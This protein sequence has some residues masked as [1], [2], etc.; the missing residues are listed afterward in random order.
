M[1]SGPGIDLSSVAVLPAPLPAAPLSTGAKPLAAAT[2]R[3]S[4]ATG[5]DAAEDLPD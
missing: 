5:D 4:S 3:N 2:R 1:S